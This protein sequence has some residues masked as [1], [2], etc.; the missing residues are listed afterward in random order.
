MVVQPLLLRLSSTNLLPPVG[1]IVGVADNSN[2]FSPHSQNTTTLLGPHCAFHSQQQVA[3]TAAAATTSYLSRATARF[4]SL[5]DSNR[6]FSSV[7][8]TSNDDERANGMPPIEPDE[9]SEDDFGWDAPTDVAEALFFNNPIQN[10]MSIR[11]TD[12]Q[13]M[14]LDLPNFVGQEEECSEK[15]LE[16]IQM[17]WYDLW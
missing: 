2:Q 5:K 13:K 17:A 9:E 15:Y 16:A 3:A 4:K 10:P 8:D 11:F 1:P 6:C 7:A 12:L 14:V